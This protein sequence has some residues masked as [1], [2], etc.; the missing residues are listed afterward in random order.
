MKLL[1]E[2]NS[3]DCGKAIDVP[4]E[5]AKKIKA[6]PNSVIIVD[7]CQNG[8]DILDIF[9]RRESGYTIYKDK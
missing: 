5:E 8:A 4:L 2:C 7:G 1:C 9:V 6:I 3:F